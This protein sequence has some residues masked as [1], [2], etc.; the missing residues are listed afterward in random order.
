[1]KIIYL[2][3]E[4]KTGKVDYGYVEYDLESIP[5]EDWLALIDGWEYRPFKVTPAD[6]L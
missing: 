4:I 2:P 1:M 3:V 6:R 5:T